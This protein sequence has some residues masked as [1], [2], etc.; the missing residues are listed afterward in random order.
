MKTEDR[1]CGRG[2]RNDWMGRGAK[3]SGRFLDGLSVHE[4]TAEAE[5]VRVRASSGGGQRAECVQSLV[6]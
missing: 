5:G 1:Q 3:R 4:L 6:D 2:V